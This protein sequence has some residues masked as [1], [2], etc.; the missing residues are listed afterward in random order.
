MTVYGHL[1]VNRARLKL[2]A[3]LQILQSCISGATRARGVIVAKRI[4]KIIKVANG[5]TTIYISL[6]K[7]KLSN[8]CKKIDSFK[9]L[10]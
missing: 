3:R 2:L 1:C 7:I 5:A 9:C 8:K 4:C 10:K 6:N